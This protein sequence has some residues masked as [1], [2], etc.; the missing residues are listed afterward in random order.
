MAKIASILPPEE[1]RAGIHKAEAVGPSSDTTVDANSEA[2]ISLTA[3]VK[4]DV[5]DLAKV[6]V[7]VEGIEG[8]PA[9]VLPKGWKVSS[10]SRTS[11]T[12][13]LAVRNVT[14]AAVTISAN[15]VKAYLTIVEGYP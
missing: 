11:I 5:G 1:K 6:A 8:L 10:L 4:L 14:T 2:T 9:G 15:S 7:G 12:V 3:S 13:D